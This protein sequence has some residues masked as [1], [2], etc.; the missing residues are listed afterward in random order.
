MM[1][2]RLIGLVM[3]GIV[4]WPAGASADSYEPV[5]PPFA[6]PHFRDPYLSTQTHVIFDV[7]GWF[8]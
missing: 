4:G 5:N 7:A 2:R 8:S 1:R 3:V 6:D